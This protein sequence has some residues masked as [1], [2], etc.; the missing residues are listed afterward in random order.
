MSVKMDTHVLHKDMLQN[1]LLRQGT[2]IP[3]RGQPRILQGLLGKGGIYLGGRGHNSIQ[4]SFTVI[5]A[6]IP[7]KETGWQNIF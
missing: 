1:M 2:A 6:L 3:L 7:F 5:I 4:L